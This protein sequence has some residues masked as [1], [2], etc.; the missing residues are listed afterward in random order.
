MENIS[1]RIEELEGEQTSLTRDVAE[2]KQEN[3]FLRVSPPRLPGGYT[4]NRKWSSSSTAWTSETS[5]R[6]H[7][8]KTPK[9]AAT[10]VTTTLRRRRRRPTRS[11]PRDIDDNPGILYNATLDIGRDAVLNMHL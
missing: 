10:D 1:K 11:S 6:P 7:R 9:R 3:K 5:H 8:I 4:K 2:L